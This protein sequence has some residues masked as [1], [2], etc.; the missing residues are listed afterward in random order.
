MKRR[1]HLFLSLHILNQRFPLPETTEFALG[2]PWH[3]GWPCLP[4][5]AK[6]SASD[7]KLKLKAHEG[8]E[9]NHQDMLQGGVLPYLTSEELHALFDTITYI[10]KKNS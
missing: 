10:R 1:I 5:T 9:S 7:L 2:E 4:L 6:I 8:E 3:C